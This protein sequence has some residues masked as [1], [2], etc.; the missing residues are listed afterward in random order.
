MSSWVIKDYENIK[1]I[2]VRPDTLVDKETESAYEVY[3]SP[4]RSPV[5]NAGTVSRINVSVFMADLLTNESLWREWQFKMPVVYN[6]W[7][8]RNKEHS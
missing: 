4:V 6:E 2:T 5:F 8:R 1:W 3:K 7:Q